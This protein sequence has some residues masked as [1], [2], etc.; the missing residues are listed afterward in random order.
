MLYAS[1]S[2]VY[3]GNKKFPFS[4]KDPVN[5]PISIYS[6]TK[7]SNELMAHVYSHLYKIPSTGLRFFTVYGPWGRPDM[8][9]MIFTKAILSNKP[10]EIY[11]NGN[12][13]RDFTYIDD[14]ITAIEKLINKPAIS[15]ENFNFQYPNPDSSWAPHKILN[16]GNNNPIKL[17]LFIN[18]LEEALGTSANK[19]FKDIQPGDVVQTFS[20]NESIKKWINFSPETPL[21]IG[22]R[23]FVKWYKKY[24]NK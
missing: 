20:D 5:H 10:I 18:Q 4:E 11:N 21:D 24:F 22:I 15:D 14:V 13:L 3:G 23:N 8:A 17:M 7:R 16:I 1:S 9:P 6:A 19:E 2:S 12:M